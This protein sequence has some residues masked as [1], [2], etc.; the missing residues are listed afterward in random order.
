MTE[1]KLIWPV[2]M[3]GQYSKI[4]LSPVPVPVSLQRTS[5]QKLN[6]VHVMYANQDK[7]CTQILINTDIQYIVTSMAP[8]KC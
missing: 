7:F 4:I 6:Y 1:Q 5:K 8:E 3:T 2:N